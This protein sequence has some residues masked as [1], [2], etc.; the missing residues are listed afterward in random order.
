MAEKKETDI[1]RASA[2]E[3]ETAFEVDGTRARYIVDYREKHGPFRNWEDVKQVPGF[4]DR[5]VENLQA[6][7]LTLSE[8]ERE[9]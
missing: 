5:M 1:N 6:A 7:G 4:E 8:Q 9:S 2:E 3:L